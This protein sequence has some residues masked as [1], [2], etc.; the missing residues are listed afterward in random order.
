VSRTKI[1]AVYPPEQT[2]KVL[3]EAVV[4]KLA[5]SSPWLY[6]ILDT[7]Y[8]PRGQLVNVAE[9]LLNG[10]ADLIQ[11]RAKDLNTNERVRCLEEIFPIFRESSTPLIV[12][13]DIEACLRFDGLGLHV[14]QDDL[15]PSDARERLGPDRVLGLST[16]SIEQAEG[17]IERGPEVLNY[18][19]VGP[20]FQTPTKP[21]YL[22]VG[23]KLVREVASRAPKLP[24]FAIGGIKP[25][26][27]EEV[28]EAGARNLVIV[29]ALLQASNP[30]WETRS[31]RE[32]MHR[33]AAASRD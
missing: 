15:D 4:M 25:F 10:G 30:E 20:V 5:K 3:A 7:K 14:G 32:Q 19:A 23:I 17:A 18:F 16:H 26:N 27:L 31:V 12:N 33:L 1:P 11:F 24:F 21:D 22:P 9:Q 8:V 6:A 13:D 2:T 28:M 29:S